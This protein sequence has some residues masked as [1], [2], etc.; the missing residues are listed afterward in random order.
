[1]R[2]NVKQFIQE[3][4]T[5]QKLDQRNPRVHVEPFTTASYAWPM[6]DLNVDTIGPYPESSEG[7]KHI[8]VIIDRMSRYVNIFPLKSTESREAVQCLLRHIAVFRKPKILRSVL[9]RYIFKYC[10]DNLAALT[11]RLKIGVG[12]CL[13]IS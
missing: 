12:F 4:P 8:L 1:M 10:F 11:V 7:Y 9:T 6:E 13:N 5:C 2:L 3:C